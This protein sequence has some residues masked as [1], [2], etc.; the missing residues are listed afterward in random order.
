MV[1][2]YVPSM[3]NKYGE[4]LALQMALKMAVKLWLWLCKMT[5]YGKNPPKF[6]QVNF[7][8]VGVTKHIAC[9]PWVISCFLS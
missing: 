1:G 4:N 3:V 8:S 5:I 6:W 9:Q 2:N 7:L